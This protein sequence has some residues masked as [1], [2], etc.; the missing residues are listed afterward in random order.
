MWLSFEKILKRALK[1]SNSN[2]LGLFN[3]HD[4]FKNIFSLL[5]A[6]H[7]FEDSSD[8]EEVS[9]RIK[10]T[11]LF[12]EEIKNNNSIADEDIYSL[13]FMKKKLS[14]VL[15][16]SEHIRYILAI[17]GVLVGSEQSDAVKYS[18]LNELDQNPTRQ[19]CHVCML[20]S[21]MN[22]LR[23]KVGSC[24]ATAVLIEMQESQ[25]SNFLML[26]RSIIEKGKI[27]ITRDGN[28]SEAYLYNRPLLNYPRQLTIY[29]S[30]IKH[31]PILRILITRICNT[32]TASEVNSAIDLLENTFYEE[33]ERHYGNF[34]EIIGAIGILSGKINIKSSVTHKTERFTRST[35]SYKRKKEDVVECYASSFEN[36][37]ILRSMEF[38]FATLS[39]SNGNLLRK[40]FTVGLGLD[41]RHHKGLQ[42]YLVEH[43]EDRVKILNQDLEYRVSAYNQMQYNDYLKTRNDQRSP[44]SEYRSMAMN[45]I[46]DIKA[47]RVFLSNVLTIFYNTFMERASEIYIEAYNPKISNDTDVDSFLGD[48]TAGF[49]LLFRGSAG[50][51][52]ISIIDDVDTFKD[53]LNRFISV[54]SGDLVSNLIS[55][56]DVREHEKIIEAEA[57]DFINKISDFISDPD[58]IK[59]A[60]TR[61]SIK[62]GL[63]LD[64]NNYPDKSIEK[65][66]SLN[67]TPWSSPTGGT[68]YNLLQNLYATSQNILKKYRA[69]NLTTAEEVLDFWKRSSLGSSSSTLLA[70]SPSHVFRLF[71][72]QIND[73]EAVFSVLGSNLENHWVFQSVVKE[74]STFL[75]IHEDRLMHA[76]NSIIELRA[77][78]LKYLNSVNSGSLIARIDCIIYTESRKIHTEDLYILFEKVAH[79]LA[80]DN[81]EELNKKFQNKPLRRDMI[82]IEDASMII[83]EFCNIHLD[84][85]IGAFVAICKIDIH[86]F[87]AHVI[88]DTNWDEGHIMF[89][90]NNITRKNEFWAFT[91]SFSVGMPIYNWN[92][93][94]HI[95]SGEWLVFY[96]TSQYSKSLPSKNMGIREERNWGRR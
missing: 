58:F 21:L 29:L 14:E 87:N 91:K 46:N 55:H 75:N 18:V 37:F 4:I 39:E 53:S 65:M 26:M 80:L 1:L 12:F 76:G 30:Q 25:T 16:N 6:K 48:I 13:E 31:A 82:T 57:R 73:I 42:N 96:D 23:Q 77:Y 70:I 64:F 88:G 79:K 83:A 54:A 78:L 38:C 11:L 93:K 66:I 34:K 33:H 49:S 41:S 15:K 43:V 92:T 60:F 3:K 62:N 74:I 90:F 28:T 72:K 51:N 5:I 71:P 7:I 63:F 59:A 95:S 94:E 50:G 8:V 89:I 32:E 22:P 20:A 24:F 27:E 86:K 17:Q 44:S 2:N 61:I 52:S 85:A 84:D 9:K 10:E 36:L 40:S 19:D 68:P 47:T 35:N 81:I 69:T 67:L 45:D 56:F